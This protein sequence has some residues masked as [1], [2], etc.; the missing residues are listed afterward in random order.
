MYFFRT[1]TGLLIFHDIENLYWWFC[2]KLWRGGGWPYIHESLTVY[3]Y[4][5]LIPYF[6]QLVAF[7]LLWQL[8]LTILTLAVTVSQHK[9]M[10]AV[11]E[12]CKHISAHIYLQ[13][14]RWQ[15]MVECLDW[16][17]IFC[18]KHA[19]LLVSFLSID[20]V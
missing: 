3:S 17:I 2:R 12:V 15:Y 20:W 4:P 8:H 1:F 14:T 19:I 6:L 5:T 7:I 13:L 11:I 9:S 18:I 10:I 16:C